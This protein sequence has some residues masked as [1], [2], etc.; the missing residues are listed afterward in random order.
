MNAS[1]CLLP[2][3]GCLL[4]ASAAHAAEVNQS[5][6]EAAR[7]GDAPR[8]QSLLRQGARVDARDAGGNTPLI[9]ASALSEDETTREAAEGRREV[10]RILL[11]RKANAQAAN[12]EGVTALMSAAA[13]RGRHNEILRLLLK[14]G[15]RV[16]AVDQRAQTAL[17]FACGEFGAVE[18]VRLLLAHKADFRLQDEEGRTV[19]WRATAGRRA[20]IVE[21]LRKAGAVE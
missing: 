11:Q 3:L 14:A 19:L 10:V 9:L 1:R 20:E 15:A 7:A 13:T 12:R 17:M 16:N 21:A 18:A 2:V 6:L 8:V 4:A 5:L